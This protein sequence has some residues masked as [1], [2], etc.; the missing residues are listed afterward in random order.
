MAG[1]EAVDILELL[2]L[3]PEPAGLSKVH[4]KDAILDLVAPAGGHVEAR[5]VRQ[6]VVKKRKRPCC[7]TGIPGPSKRSKS[8]HAVIVRLMN[9]GRALKREQEKHSLVPVNV[10][11]GPD[12]VT[13]HRQKLAVAFS[14]SSRIVAVARAHSVS[15]KHCRH[16]T[17]SAAL[18]TKLM[19]SVL[20]D[21]IKAVVKQ[22]FDDGMKLR[23]FA[24]HLVF[25]GADQ[26]MSIACHAELGRDQRT[27][28]WHILS[29]FRHPWIGQY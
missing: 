10:D 9:A 17:Q 3:D 2:G 19:F 6:Q 26:T 4:A 21:R 1:G 15:T 24:D 23:F 28:P 8:D 20:L 18:C 25:D 16:I 13:T 14:S 5:P 27:T 29:S 12:F 22:N 7:N 11:D